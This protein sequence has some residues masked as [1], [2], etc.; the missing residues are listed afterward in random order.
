MSQISEWPLSGKKS[1]SAPQQ[2]QKSR[3]PLPFGTVTLCRMIRGQETT[4]PKEQCSREDEWSPEAGLR[5]ACWP[6]GLRRA[7]LH[8]VQG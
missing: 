8:K 2:S 6:G 4:E 3:C 1:L 5:S 7:T